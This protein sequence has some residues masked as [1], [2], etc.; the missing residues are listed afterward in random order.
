MWVQGIEEQIN[1]VI[2]SFSFFFFFLFG[3][4]LAKHRLPQTCILYIQL[5][6]NELQSYMC[7]PSLESKDPVS[8]LE[9]MCLQDDKPSL[10]K[11]N[12]NKR[13]LNKKKNKMRNILTNITF[14]WTD[15]LFFWYR[16]N[17]SRPNFKRTKHS[18]TKIVTL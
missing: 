2:E 6:S 16:L 12:L 14:R 4:K 1:Y 13:I 11:E 9:T 18:F 10:R 3:F 15:T 8:R 5:K 7:Q 17:S